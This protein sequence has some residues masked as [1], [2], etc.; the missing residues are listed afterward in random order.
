M[1]GSADGS[2]SLAASVSMAV[3][4]LEGRINAAATNGVRW[5]S[6]S[7]LVAIVSHFPKLKTELEVLRSER[8][9]VLIEDEA[10]ALWIQVCAAS[11]L[12]ASHIPSSVARNHPDTMGEKWW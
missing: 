11:D 9:I 3:E 10:D 5:G 12:L 7:A 2:S 6:H 1:L 8:S 4:P